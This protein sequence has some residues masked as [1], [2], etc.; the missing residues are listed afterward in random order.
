M[1][2]LHVYSHSGAPNEPEAVGVNGPVIGFYSGKH[3]VLCEQ[4]DLVRC[5]SLHH[6]RTEKPEGPFL[7]P[8][9]LTPDA[10]PQTNKSPHLLLN[11]ET[12]AGRTHVCRPNA[13]L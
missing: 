9:L 4:V 2:P 3:T 12:P 7:Y 11:T 10:A 13:A 1:E 5:L 8:K 6:S